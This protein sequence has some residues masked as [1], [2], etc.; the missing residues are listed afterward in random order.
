MS[1]ELVSNRV[2]TPKNA[3]KKLWSKSFQ[4]FS[5]CINSPMQHYRYTPLAF[6]NFHALLIFNQCSKL[7]GTILSQTEILHSSTTYQ[8]S[9]SAKTNLH[10]LGWCFL[11]SWAPSC[12][13]FGCIWQNLQQPAKIFHSMHNL[14][15]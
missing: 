3:H 8:N 15:T 10:S 4:G 12:M 9:K 6:S 2:T 7:P 14:V 13:S 5:L 11:N 1:E